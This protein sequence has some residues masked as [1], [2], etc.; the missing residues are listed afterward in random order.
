MGSS[1]RPEP[2]DERKIPPADL[3]D[4]KIAEGMSPDSAT[5]YVSRIHGAPPAAAAP[6]RQPLIRNTQA[7]TVRPDATASDRR[8]PANYYRD[9]LAGG[10]RTIEQGAT[11]GFGD[12]LNAG[13][14]ALMPGQTLADALADERT[15]VAGFRERHPV[16]AIGAE[17]LGGMGGGKVLG[18]AGRAA[19]LPGMAPATTGVGRALRSTAAG[20]AVGGVAAAGS[21]EGD[22][23]DRIRAMPRGMAFGAA[24][25]ATMNA[26]GAAVKTGGKALANRASQP[27]MVGKALRSAGIP[28]ASRSRARRPDSP[29]GAQRHVD[30]RCRACCGRGRIGDDA[31]G[32]R[33]GEFG[34]A[35]SHPRRTDDPVEGL[36]ANRQGAHERVSN[37]PGRVQALVSK[38]LNGGQPRENAVEAAQKLIT[39]AAPAPS[40]SMSG[41]QGGAD[42]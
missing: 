26:A 12:E 11:L 8:V 16:G 21:A 32:R 4:K 34:P 36:A 25:A 15:S 38:G 39:L 28:T 27:T 37:Q 13:I 1:V 29:V 14:R 10:L 18:L 30:R 22:V 40:R 9:D 17:V 19:G 3:W 42:R 20:A 2:T 24:T 6:S 23:S 31:D 35:A 7:S 33:R 41:V 5:A